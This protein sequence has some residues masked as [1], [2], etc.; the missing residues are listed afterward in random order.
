MAGGGAGQRACRRPEMMLMRSTTMART[1][2]MCM[3][4]PRVYELT[5]PS[6]QSTSRITKIVQ[7]IVTSKLSGIACVVREWWDSPQDE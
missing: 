3:N 6:N 7:S 1:R 5:R 4:P 2:R